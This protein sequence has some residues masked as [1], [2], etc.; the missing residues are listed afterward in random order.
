MSRLGLK[1]AARE[2]SDLREGFQRARGGKDLGMCLRIQAL[3]P[4]SQGGRGD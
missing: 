3:L 1:L 4:V 2:R